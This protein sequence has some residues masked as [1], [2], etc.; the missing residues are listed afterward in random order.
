ME[1][2]VSRLTLADDASGIEQLRQWIDARNVDDECDGLFVQL[3]LA[4]RSEHD[5]AVRD[6][7]RSIAAHKDVDALSGSNR[8]PFV[9]ATA[10]GV[11]SLIDYFRI[12]TVGK[13]VLLLGK[14]QRSTAPLVTPLSTYPYYGTV[15]QCDAFTNN[16][17]ALTRSADIIVTATGAAHSL[18]RQHIRANAVLIDVGIARINDTVVGDVEPSCYDVASAYTVVPGGVGQLTVKTFC[19]FYIY[20]FLKYFFFFVGCFVGSQCYEFGSITSWLAA[21][22]YASNVAWHALS[23]TSFNDNNGTD[24]SYENHR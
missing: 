24:N 13:H 3:P 16:L 15:T 4:S 9:A 10:L 23:C 20:L 22:R 14:G 6:A 17:H 19:Y 2:R 5:V 18:R 11:L 8:S 21:A 12:D 1:L 7:L